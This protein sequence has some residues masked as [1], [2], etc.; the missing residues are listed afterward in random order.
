MQRHLRRPLPGLRLVVSNLEEFRGD[1]QTARLA[2]LEKPKLVAIGDPVGDPH[3]RNRRFP[4]SA[5]KRA[6]LLGAPKGVD[7]VRNAFDLSHRLEDSPNSLDTSS[8][9]SL[10]L[11]LARRRGRFPP[12]SLRQTVRDLD[13][14]SKRVIAMRE[15]KTWSQTE[16]AHFC[17]IS[18]TTWNNYE[19]AVSRPTAENLAAMCEVF[20][21]TAD[22]ILFG[23]TRDVPAP[24]L[25]RLYGRSA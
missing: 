10:G 1:R 20:G 14:M 15:A 23:V 25:E 4:D 21:V 2:F 6:E 11:I 16:A 18:K 17:K 13:A 8:P 22:F 24:I 9:I 12:M 5:A 19:T 3:G 7:Q